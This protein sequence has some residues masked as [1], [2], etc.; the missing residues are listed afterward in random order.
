MVRTKKERHRKVCLHGNTKTRCSLAL[1]LLS[2]NKREHNI[3]VYAYLNTELSLRSTF[4]E[5][6]FFCNSFYCGLAKLGRQEK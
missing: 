2:L 4:G 6:A 5:G 1:F 3:E